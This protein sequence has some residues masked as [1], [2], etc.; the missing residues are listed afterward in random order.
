[1]S[2]FLEFAPTGEW[3]NRSG[4]RVALR[5][6][7]QAV[8]G[9]LPGDAPGVGDAVTVLAPY[10]RGDGP[11]GVVAS[12]SSRGEFV[13]TLTYPAHLGR[14]LDVAEVLR[15][16]LLP[17]LSLPL[18]RKVFDAYGAKALTA[19]ARNGIAVGQWLE[20]KEDV[21]R[22]LAWEGQ[23]AYR[24]ALGWAVL[25][26]LDLSPGECANTI[27]SLGARFLEVVLRSPYV[28][29]EV[30]G[31]GFGSA[32]RAAGVL[33]AQD[34]DER[35]H[36][37]IDLEMARALESGDTAVRQQD[38]VRRLVQRLRTTGEDVHSAL[39]HSAASGTLEMRVSGTGQ[40][41]LSVAQ[42]AAERSIVDEV[43]RLATAQ[44]TPPPPVRTEFHDRYSSD[45]HAAL[46]IVA[47]A[48]VSILSGGPGTG[49]TTLLKGVLERFQATGGRIVLSAPTGKA[50]RRMSEVC[51][52]P[53]QT[54]HAL[55]KADRTGRFAVTGSVKMG[56]RLLV[57]DESSMID[58]TLF[59]AVLRA[60]PTG[61]RLL[62]CGDPDQLPPVG[63]GAVFADL[64]SSGTI[65][66]G[67]LVQ[68]H[69][70]SSGILQAANA[71][72][73]GTVPEAMST[74]GT[75]DNE[76][77]WGDA[78]GEAAAADRV[79]QAVVDAVPAALGCGPRDVQ[80]LAPVH[81][82]R[83]GVL[84][85]NQRLKER[86]NPA[87][88]HE[89]MEVYE[90]HYSVEDP[91]VWKA[92]DY[93]LGLRNGD[94]GVIEAFDRGEHSALISFDGRSVEVPINRFD[95]VD[96]A[97][98]LTVHR[99]QGSEYEAVVVPVVG[100]HK[101]GL[102][103]ELLYTALTRAKR[104]VC[105]VGEKEALKGALNVSAG[106]KRSSSLA[107]ALS[108]RLPIWHDLRGQEEG[109]SAADASP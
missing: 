6:V 99:S 73:I 78:A 26:D 33:G 104:H 35:L 40:Y 94:I 43:V 39:E 86:L 12:W 9:P 17:S 103:R 101:A 80:V 71:M 63:P 107:A 109:P 29:A 102:S 1:M 22:G 75:G 105:F 5:G 91:V 25:R 76:V 56:A 19:M 98:A 82:G 46:E 24:S 37:A 65:A 27:E 92:N 87:G 108:R 23:R 15:S 50:A 74:F 57:V 13:A 28:L 21:C 100:A 61:A 45:Q 14:T 95:N 62:L 36:K 7:L 93:R 83:A 30:P 32:E 42:A 48:P 2:A 67:K 64:I 38:L 84:L 97:Y 20:L 55:L 4:G 89:T 16:P 8:R 59:A 54:L 11:L 60:L 58:S 79:V 31:I 68:Q 10:R 49:K 106:S 3:E 72:R 69:R 18:A 85:L 47:Q 34:P 70:Q 53:A 44:M 96:L 52:M 81:A 90:R 88:K 51:G 77:W 41:V 66:H